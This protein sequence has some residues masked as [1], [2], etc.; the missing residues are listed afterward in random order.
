MTKTE[1]QPLTCVVCDRE[2]M[3]EVMNFE[4]VTYTCP[5][6]QLLFRA[7]QKKQKGQIQALGDYLK[8]YGNDSER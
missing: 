6:C 8:E 7:W 3:W 2:L 4:D 5:E 1:H